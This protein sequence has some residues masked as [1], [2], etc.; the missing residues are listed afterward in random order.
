[1]RNIPQ[2]AGP[3]QPPLKDSRP[4]PAEAPRPATDTIPVDPQGWYP[5]MG[6]GPLPPAWGHQPMTAFGSLF[7]EDFEPAE[8]Y[9]VLFPGPAIRRADHDP[10]LI[11]QDDR[12]ADIPVV[13]IGPVD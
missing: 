10:R 11:G 6:F 2:T 4:A 12:G 5:W 3:G 13:A 1:M 7:P 9:V 8:L